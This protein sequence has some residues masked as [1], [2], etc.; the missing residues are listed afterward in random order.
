MI[1]VW[2]CGIMLAIA[3][4]AVLYRVIKGPGMLDRVVAVDIL[5]T[6]LVAAVGLE[7]AWNRHTY[8]LPVLVV[9]AM[10]GFLSSSTVARFSAR[11][12]EEP[13]VDVNTILNA[14]RAARKEYEEK[15]QG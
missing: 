14:R 15:G 3:L 13:D 10:V 7:A 11:D 4:A 9:L 12:P 6:V 5:V 1:G 2:L 8:T